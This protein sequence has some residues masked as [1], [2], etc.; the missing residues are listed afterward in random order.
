M[1]RL[2]FSAD[3]RFE[4]SPAELDRG[5]RSYTVETLRELKKIYPGDELYLI[6]GS[7]MLET[8]PGWYRWEE[9]FSL[10]FV[11]SASRKND[12]KFDLSKFG[13]KNAKRI[14]LLDLPPLEVGSS[15][16]RDVIAAGGRSEFLDPGVAAYVEKK[17]LYSDGLEKYRRLLAEKL[18]KERI[19]HSERVSESAAA[20]AERYGADAEKARLAGLLHDVM[21]NA[22]A[23]EQLSVLEAA[24]EKL[25]DAD[26]ANPEVLHQFSG[27]AFLKINGIVEDEEILGAVRRHTTGGANM[28]VLEKIVYAADFI[29]ADRKYPGVETVRRLARLSLEHVALYAAR[30][31][32]GKLLSND[33]PINP[34][35]VACYDD[36]TLYFMGRK[37][38]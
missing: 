14:I 32:V 23:E 24:G 1:C 25:S 31:T 18:D 37:G 4:I 13:E 21:K 33:L 16:I 7:D 17:G 38:K 28:S 34:A 2:A 30:Y 35:T 9:I 27:A 8:L 6:V 36:A 26:L 20:L 19:Y 10:A 29:S 12:L 3:E 5:S 22:P 11:C 15:G